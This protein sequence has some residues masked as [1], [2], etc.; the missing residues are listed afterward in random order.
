MNDLIA[1]ARASGTLALHGI[2]LLDPHLRSHLATTTD[3]EQ[4]Y[5]EGGQKDLG[6]V[7]SNH[8]GEAMTA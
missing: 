3:E 4:R 8:A 6:T 5:Q 7:A 2:D 1:G